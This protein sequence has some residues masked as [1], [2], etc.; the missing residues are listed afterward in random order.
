MNRRKPKIT[1]EGHIKRE[2]LS[3]AIASQKR[4]DE[5]VGDCVMRG[6]KALVASAAPPGPCTV[7]WMVCNATNG[8]PPTKRHVT[9]DR[10][11][12]ETIRLAREHPRQVFVLLEATHGFYT[13]DSGAVHK[14]NLV[15]CVN[16]QLPQQGKS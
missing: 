5:T 3:A 8:G 14:M 10:A 4:D 16:A 15:H 6:M 11:Y 9:H 7:F 2:A 13:D 1:R 12:N